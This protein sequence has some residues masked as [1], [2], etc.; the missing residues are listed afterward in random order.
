MRETQHSQ[1]PIIPCLILWNTQGH[2]VNTLLGTW[3]SAKAQTTSEN[4][5]DWN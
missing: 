4:S 3:A 2:L 5:G 1:I